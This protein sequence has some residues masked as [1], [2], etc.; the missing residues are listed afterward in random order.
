MAYQGL[1]F[2]LQLFEPKAKTEIFLNERNKPQPLLLS[3][4][5]LWKW[6]SA[7][8]LMFLSEFNVKLQG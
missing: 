5:W 2:F 8:V 3:T 1:M 6:A 4:E 7:E